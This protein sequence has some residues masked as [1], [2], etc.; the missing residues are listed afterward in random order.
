[1]TREWP[2]PDFDKET[3]GP[4]ETIPCPVCGASATEPCNENCETLAPLDKPGDVDWSSV[5]DAWA[6]SPWAQELTE[7]GTP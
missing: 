6:H 2:A 1:M 4:D 3:D 7:D 5:A